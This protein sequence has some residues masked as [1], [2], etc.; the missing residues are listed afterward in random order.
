MGW[1]ERTKD[2]IDFISPLKSHFSAFWIANERSHE[3]SLGIFKYPKI[4]G[5]V[6]QD[7]D[8]GGISYPLNFFFSGADHDIEA[9]AFFEASKENGLWEITHP[10]VI[11]LLNLQLVSI[12]EDANR[13]DNSN[14]SL[15]TSQWLEPI[16]PIIVISVSQSEENI[17]TQSEVVNNSASGQFQR[18]TSQ[19]NASL[20]SAMANS[21]RSLLDHIKSAMATLNE[22]NAEIN[23]YINSVNRAIND[24]LNQVI[25]NPLRLASQFQQLIQVPIQATNNIESRLGALSDLSALIF[26]MTPDTPTGESANIASVM[27]MGITALLTAASQSVIGGDLRTRRQ[28]VE[29][30]ELLS[31][32][33]I[34]N[35]DGLDEI[36]KL[37]ENQRAN[38]Q[39]FSQS[40]SFADVSLLIYQAVDL[41]VKASFDLSVE[42]RIILKRPRAP[43]EITITEYGDLGEE[44]DSNLDFFIETNK[45]SGN[46]ILLLPAGKEVLVYV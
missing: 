39:Y 33:F 7:L 17:S 2:T 10:T 15:F 36:Q 29:I 19:K 38:R 8:S 14:I 5:V 1:P 22:L 18:F 3:K 45:L 20:R 34:N 28:A 26:T 31:Q 41:A 27:D 24:T 32:L 11:G 30:A 23:A 16:S 4:K 43:I 25:I 46:E 9:Q 13:G 44:N 42:K 35:V 6:V 12:S 37:F 40:E 21:S